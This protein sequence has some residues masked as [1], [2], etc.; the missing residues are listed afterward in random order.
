MATCR[1]CGESAGVFRQEHPDC[2]TTY[3]NGWQQ[4]RELV[5]DAV[6][7][8]KGPEQLINELTAIAKNSLVA[9]DQIRNALI[10][11]W[12]AAVE[13]FLE[14][15]ILTP[16]EETQ[17]VTFKN[18][19]GLE[20]NELD[21]RGAFSTILKSAILRDLLEGKLPE[22][23]EVAGML[24]FNFHKL[25]KLVWLFQ[26][27]HYY[28]DKTRRQYVG[29]SHGVSI[30]IM[31][32][33]YYRTGSF[34]GHPIETTERAYIDSG[35]LAI[36]DKHLYFAGSSKSFRIPYTKIVSITPYSDGVTVQRDAMTAKPQTFLTHDGWF[37]YNLTM[38]LSGLAN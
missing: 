9:S 34:R 15:G 11:G 14:D 6:L 23:V 25:E 35:I 21:V 24:L 20:Q 7:Q 27:V 36:T 4:L 31:K 32:G 2:V 17:L 5:R 28:E 10:T 22:R 1:Y 26:G 12:E 16:E 18:R 8:G 33:V 13:R 29:R 30:R 19:F 38:N 3:N 37:T